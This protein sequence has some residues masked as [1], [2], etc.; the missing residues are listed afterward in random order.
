MN[1]LIVDFSSIFLTY[2]KQEIVS[3]G[4]PHRATARLMQWLDAKI[5]Q[6]NSS[7][8]YTITPNLTDLSIN[9]PDEAYFFKA[10]KLWA[11]K[12]HTFHV[13]TSKE[14]SSLDFVLSI[15]NQLSGTIEI[16]SSDLRMTQLLSDKN[17]ILQPVR[18]SAYSAHDLAS[19][20]GGLRPEQIPAFLALIGHSESQTPPIAGLQNSLDLILSSD[21][22]PAK[23][24]A[25]AKKRSEYDFVNISRSERHIK[26]NLKKT[27]ARA[28]S[29]ELQ[30]IPRLWDASAAAQLSKMLLRE[31]IAPKALNLPNITVSVV[32]VTDQ[33]AL[34]DLI[35]IGNHSKA[36][37]LITEKDNTGI[38][39]VTISFKDGSAFY[40][41]LNKQNG[42]HV[43]TE[44][45]VNTLKGLIESNKKIVTFS[46]YELSRDLISLGIKSD[47]ISADCAS[48]RYLI[49][50]RDYITDISDLH[51]S[52]DQNLPLPT[53]AEFIARE[54]RGLAQ[55][56]GIDKCSVFSGMR[57]DLVWRN[58]KSIF[59]DIS[60]ANLK[61]QYSDY[62]IR[63]AKVCAEMSTRG[64]QVDLPGIEASKAKSKA[65][66][67]NVY[68][69]IQALYPNKEFSLTNEAD[70]VEILKSF[71]LKTKATAKG[72]ASINKEELIA[73]AD[74]HPV[75]PMIQLGRSMH[76]SISKGLE[77][78]K[79]HS[80]PE[81]IVRCTFVVN[82]TLTSRLSTIEPNAHGSTDL[83]R[84]HMI[85]RKGLAIGCFDIS[86]ME[87]RVL[88]HLSGEQILVDAFN[89]GLDIHVR[90]ASEIF[91]CNIHEVTENQR[92]IAKTINFGL[93]YGM[94]A[95]GMAKRINVSQNT[96]QDYIDLY[97]DKMPRVKE[98]QSEQLNQVR[99]DGYYQLENGR[100]IYFPEINNS[101]RTIRS[102]AERSAINAP[103]QATASE[104]VKRGMIK[105]KDNLAQA[106]LNA[107]MI[108]QVHDELIFEMPIPELKLCQK[109]ITESIETAYPMSVPIVVESFLGLSMSKKQNHLRDLNANN[110]LTF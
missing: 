36:F 6:D 99:R 63:Q 108:L 13:Q 86:Q 49:N 73:I 57:S 7:S 82:K 19:E 101:D 55:N 37:S 47:C 24:V 11:E 58:S 41:P 97:F 40:V 93:I 23:L 80:D 20:L 56:A 83:M 106:G 103:M 29:L 68:A 28:H 66:L 9:E 90:T 61:S 59:R 22:S 87:L 12:N 27:T 25:A 92:K 34:N 89:Q 21:P 107:H 84:Q 78:L 38:Y 74:K 67:D 42:Q 76:E 39:A 104:I 15:Q 100:K 109:I 14:I 85:A 72:A 4:T 88:A 79:R 62:D 96:A 3:D 51:Q 2:V 1:S 60:E 5:S 94:S 48:G 16:A 77:T 75:V 32:Q 54:G 71:N 50:T 98:F 26:E 35:N 17:L 46:A 110:E 44:D 53:S 18:E 81:G 52:S 64:I 8:I 70:V 10:A 31:A 45:V 105:S 95:I 91:G 43:P 33:A 69:S 65:A 102:G 30:E